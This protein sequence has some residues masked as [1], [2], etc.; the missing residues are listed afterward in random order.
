[1]SDDKALAKEEI[2]AGVVAVPIALVVIAA[3][4]ARRR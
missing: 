1:M 3:V 2:E 4:S